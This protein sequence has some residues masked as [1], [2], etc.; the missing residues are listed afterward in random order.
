MSGMTDVILSLSTNI[1]VPLGS[2]L[3]DWDTKNRHRKTREDYFEMVTRR[4]RND[5]SMSLGVDI[6]FSKSILTLK[7]N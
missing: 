4:P 1:K 6:S 5:S 3:E 2:L 7:S